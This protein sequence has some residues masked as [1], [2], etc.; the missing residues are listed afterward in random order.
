LESIQICKQ[1]DDNPIYPPIFENYQGEIEMVHSKYWK[2]VDIIDKNILIIGGATSAIEIAEEIG[3]LENVNPVT[4]VC[5]NKINISGQKFLG[6]VDYHHIVYKFG[7][8]P[9]WVT[10]SYCEKRPTLPGTDLGFNLLRQQ[11]R[12]ILLGKEEITDIIG[13]TVYFTKSEGKEFDLIICCTGYSFSM[14]FLPNIERSQYTGHPIAENNESSTLRNLF[15]IGTP[16]ARQVSSEFLRGISQDSEYIAKVIH[17]RI[18]Q[19]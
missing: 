18:Y 2:D 19:T 14:P 16:C 9:K 5:R 11:G 3:K 10:G 15:F 12:I 4:I 6:L 1:Y 17:S 8:I 13:K 7:W